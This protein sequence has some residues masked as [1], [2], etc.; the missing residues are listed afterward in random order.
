MPTILVVDDSALDRRLVSGLLGKSLDCTVVE[1]TGGTEALE[2]L[3]CHPVDVVLADLQMPGMSGLELVAAI[4]SN[5]PRTPVILMTAQGSEEIAAEALR[6]G[7]ASYVLKK[8]LAADLIPTVQH[9]LTASREDRT[10]PLL[11]HFLETTDSVFVLPND[12][13]LIQSVVSHAQQL[14]HCLPLRDE[15][16]RLRVGVALEE[17]LKNAYYH[18]NLEVGATLAKVDHQAYDQLACQRN[19]EAPYQDRR[20][21]VRLRVSRHEATFTVTDEGLGFDHASL[22]TTIDLSDIQRGSARGVILMRSIMDEVTYNQTGNE[23]TLIK[24]RAP[25]SDEDPR[26]S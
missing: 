9:I 5:Y 16:E 18:G 2:K 24:H 7:A 22:P 12:L 1:A 8:K 26:P 10:Y 13:V 11:M 14:L 4:K 21:R 6:R 23:V 20:I 25:E 17:A 15:T 19:T 3:Q